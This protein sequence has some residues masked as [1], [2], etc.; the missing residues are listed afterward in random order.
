MRP[1]LY[2]ARAMEHS[3]PHS[4]A[5]PPKPHRQEQE[6]AQREITQLAPNV[7]R[8]QLPISMPGLGHVNMYALIDER[9]AA[10]VDPG[11]PTPSNWKAIQDRLAQA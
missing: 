9:G 10:V 3:H 6:T 8:M 5:H 4:Q 2:L 1:N 11:L 7:L